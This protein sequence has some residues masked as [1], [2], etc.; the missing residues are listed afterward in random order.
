MYDEALA[1]RIR[2]QLGTVQPFTERKMFGGIAFLINGNMACGIMRDE[3]MA[4]TGRE[5]FAEALGRPHTRPMDVTGRPMTG[6]LFVG[7][8]GP[9]SD[10]ELAEWVTLC[11]AYA[12]SLPPKTAVTRGRMLPRRRTRRAA[13][14]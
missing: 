6:M 3:L 4:R 2:F 10:E 5:R 14:R 12:S 1:Q 7:A 9:G 11:A 8:E 13:D